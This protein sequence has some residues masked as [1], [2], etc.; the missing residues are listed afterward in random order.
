MQHDVQ[1][2]SRVVSY[3]RVHTCGIVMYCCI[4]LQCHMCAHDDWAQEPEC[5]Y[6]VCLTA[7]LW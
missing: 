1:E 4:T 2:L 3:S 5:T 6:V 7:G